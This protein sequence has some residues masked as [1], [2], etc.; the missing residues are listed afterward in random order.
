MV[1]IITGDGDGLSIGGNHLLHACRRNTDVKIILFNNRIYGLTKGQYSPTSVPG[2]KTKSSPMGPLEA[3]FNPLS[4]ALG[5]EASFVARTMDANPKHMA[6]VIARAA[7]HKGT[8]FVEVL[9]NCVIFNNGT[10]SFVTDPEVRDD[11]SL[12][13]EHGQPMIF[14]KARDKGLRLR[15]LKP[16]VVNVA[17]V[18]ADQLLVHDE[19]DSDITLA[20]MLSRLTFPDYPMPM[21]VL[22]AVERPT[23]EEGVR[24]QVAQAQKTRGVGDLRSLY[25]SGETWQVNRHDDEEHEHDHD[26]LG[27]L[28]LGTRGPNE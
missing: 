18:P 27:Q 10:W 5:A 14:G 28:F 25:S 11:H 4:V 2:T 9:Q 3:A 12:N 16:E 22:R 20:M 21:G 15:G 19:R 23:Y 24:G 6:D 1:F 26:A 8:A 13:L 17:D 7:R